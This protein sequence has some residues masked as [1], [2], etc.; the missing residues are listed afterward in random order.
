MNGINFQANRQIW[1]RF[2]EVVKIFVQSDVGKKALQL[3]GALVLL[4]LAVNGFNVVNSYVGRDFMTA[5][6]ERNESAFFWKAMLY[7]GVFG[8]STV[9]AVLHRYTEDNLGMLFREWLT[10]RLTNAYLENRAYYRLK[11]GE[12]I[13]NPDERIA[14]D[15][16]TYTITTLSI[17]LMLM[18]ASLTVILFS[19]VLWSISAPLFLIAIVYSLAGSYVAIKLGRPLVGLNSTQL[20]K[21]ADFR[22]SLIHVR[23][24][25]ESIAL[26]RREGRLQ[27]RLQGRITAFAEN[28][29]QIFVVSRNLNFF[30]TGYFN[31]IQVVPVII[32]APL[33]FRG[34][35]EFG[36]ITQ[37][38]M[39]FAQLVNAFSL[40]VSQFQPLSS[41]T[42]VAS[43]LNY[44]WEAMESMQNIGESKIEVVETNEK[45]IT[46]QN[47]T[48]RSVENKRV[49]LKDFSLSIPHGMRLLIAG[50]NEAAK[51]ALFRATAGIFDHGEG[52]IIRPSLDSI[53]FLPQRAY[54]YPGTLREL[55]LRSSEEHVISDERMVNTLRELGLGAV[56][57]QVG[58][59]D[60]EQNWES[61]LSLGEEQI[62]A[63]TR[64]VL[65]APQFAFLDRVYTSL[66]PD[67]ASQLLLML[68]MHSISYIAMDEATNMPQLYDAILE[69]ANDG[70]WKVKAN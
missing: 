10:K 9:V 67:Q 38:A 30:S 40:V 50:P 51:L 29:R 6:A 53:R 42:A 70:S 36:V 58:G 64:L 1:L 4:M 44:L 68:S 11:T 62:L 8:V 22:A 28:M 41:F 3:S 46:Y 37:S 66:T 27:A 32:V 60:V 61:M 33:Y 5:T 16:R 55:L 57:T 45:H 43:R 54:L 56:L 31:L 19:G 48:L 47:L 23:E 39:V 17:V 7:I 49:L 15:V 63:F 12:E 18:N 2:I 34:E 21:E 35:V 26:T 14:D 25:A 24:N 69:I 52:K 65:A 20:D 59:L 13:K